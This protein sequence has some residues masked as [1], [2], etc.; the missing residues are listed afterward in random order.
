MCMTM[1]YTR[2]DKHTDLS[3]EI[4][5]GNVTAELLQSLWVDRNFSWLPLDHYSKGTSSTTISPERGGTPSLILDGKEIFYNNP[6]R[7]NN[8]NTTAHESFRMGPQSGEFS[9]ELLKALG[10]SLGRHGVL[11]LYERLKDKSSKD[12]AYILKSTPEIFKL[13]PHQF[14]SLQTIQLEKRQADF[15]LSIQN[16]GAHDL[17]FA[18]G[19]H[20]FYKV[21]VDKKD[22]IELD[23]NMQLTNNMIKSRI[24]WWEAIQI[25][26]PWTCKIWIPWIGEI[27]V[28]YD[29]KFKYLQLRSIKDAW[30]VCIEPIV[31][32][33]TN[34]LQSAILTK[35]GDILNIGFSITLLSK[36]NVL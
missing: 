24:D 19:H 22:K 35:P 12:I 1:N 27:Q 30:F 17:P 23:E 36:D 18:P 2:I 14:T 28:D 3:K 5:D 32:K 26:N 7:R 15:S 20:T 8:L 33:A 6:E 11:R 16:T 21:D 34:W 4:R 25:P 29:P 13:F 10:Y 9:S 31:D